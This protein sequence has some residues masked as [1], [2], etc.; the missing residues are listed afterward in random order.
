MSIHANITRFAI[1]LFTLLVNTAHAKAP[2]FNSTEHRV[3]G[4][5]VQLHWQINEAATTDNILLLHNG[6]QLKLGDIMALGGDFYGDPDLPIDDGKTIEAKKIRFLVAFETLS[7][8]T[9]AVNEAPQILK[10]IS[11]EQTNIEKA[12][13]NGVDESVAYEQ[14]DDQFNQQYNN[15]T[16]GGTFLSPLGRYTYLALTDWDHFGS[17]AIS[18]YSAGHAAALDT[19]EKAFHAPDLDTR[20]QLL[21]LAYAQD[22][23]ACHYLSDL[24]SSGHLRTPRKELNDKVTP[25][26]L[27][28]LLSKY[29]H[30]EEGRMGLWVNNQRGDV[31]QLFGDGYIF[32]DKD[33]L[34]RKYALLALQTSFDEIWQAAQNGQ[35][36]TDYQALSIVPDLQGATINDTSLNHAPLFKMDEK[37]KVLMRRM[38]INAT[39]N[40]TYSRWWS[41]VD[42]LGELMSEYRPKGAVANAQKISAV[43][44]AFR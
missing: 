19:A 34:N 18:A 42:M 14:L 31:W 4:N 22:A 17:H 40:Y 9:E 41:G 26:A 35:I 11:E 10:M 20:K 43:H 44:A 8:S 16:G 29:M 13:E 25:S 6:L 33:K 37:S 2:T 27:G 24:F 30:D 36:P 32:M 12:M 28:A 3:L 38:G 1:V 23:F 7:E 5:E 15:L 39:D 21:T